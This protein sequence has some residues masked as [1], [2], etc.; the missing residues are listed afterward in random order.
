MGIKN[1]VVSDI[2]GA[3]IPDGEAVELI[4]RSHPKLEAA[5]RLD[6]SASEVAGLKDAS[7]VVVVE[8]KHNGETSTKTVTLA[9]FERVVPNKALSNGAPTRGRRR[10]T[11][12]A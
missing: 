4:V 7:N 11:R 5:R 6:V 2:S 3:E 8:L 1:V 10:G 9:D 12:L